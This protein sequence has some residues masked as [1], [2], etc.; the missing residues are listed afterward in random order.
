[1]NLQLPS[2]TRNKKK[3]R[4][5]LYEKKNNI[6]EGKKKELAGVCWKHKKYVKDR[7]ANTG[8]RTRN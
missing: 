6:H 1:M 2:V 4:I 8:K 3:Q 5:K 7:A